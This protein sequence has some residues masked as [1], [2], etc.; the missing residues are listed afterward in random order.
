MTPARTRLANTWATGELRVGAALLLPLLLTLAGCTT[1]TPS[2]VPPSVAPVAADPEP[3][4]YTAG[5]LGAFQARQREAAEAAMRGGQWADALWALDVLLALRPGDAALAEQRAQAERAAT[6][7]AAVRLQRARQA[8]QRGDAD[9]A[10]RLYLEALALTPGDAA[11]AQALR[12]IERERVRRQHLGQ[13]SRNTLARRS[14]SESTM[15]APLPTP[16]GSAAG[17]AAASTAS[18]PPGSLPNSERN[19]V[20]HAS[21]LAAQGEV[22]AA[23]AVLRPLALAR[24]PD[25]MARRLLADLYVRQAEALLPVDRAGALAALERSLQADPSQSRAAVLLK[26]WSAAPDSG[27]TK[28][29]PARPSRPAAR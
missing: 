7:A 21:M 20:E 12:Q 29:L 2:P 5:A 24:R 11:A 16:G 10:T 15:A 23:I 1:P 25:P 6:A 3:E 19:E 28:S 8:Q 26:E 9:A 13:L 4:P 22:D 17:P 14:A 27:G 18:N